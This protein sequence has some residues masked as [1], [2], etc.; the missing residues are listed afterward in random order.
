MSGV[1]VEDKVRE[2]TG[3]RIFLRGDRAA[4]GFGLL[5]LGFVPLVELDRDNELFRMGLGVNVVVTLLWMSLLLTCTCFI[6]DSRSL[7]E[8][9]AEALEDDRL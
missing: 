7:E 5:L 9:L 4:A 1:P 2:G 6:F 8:S 3:T